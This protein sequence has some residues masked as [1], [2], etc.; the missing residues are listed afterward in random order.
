MLEE[1]CKRIQQLLRYA[2]VITEQKKCWE[3]LA[4]KFDQFQT[5]RNSSQQ[6]ATTC[7]RV[8]KR[9]QHRTSDNV[10]SVCKGLKVTSEFCLRSSL[11]VYIW[12]DNPH[13]LKS[14][15][16]VPIARDGTSNAFLVMRPP[17]CVFPN[18]RCSELD[19]HRQQNNNNGAIAHAPKMNFQTIPIPLDTNTVCKW[20]TLSWLCFY[21]SYNTFDICV[22]MSTLSSWQP[23]QL[24]KQEKLWR[25]VGS[26]GT[27]GC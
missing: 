6:H 7:N 3:S 2:S 19:C 20:S 16:I 10:A 24:W 1:L 12:S 23:M 21:S 4:Q 18:T 25:Q 17:F 13:T 5:L 8:C 26:T 9:T 22:C 27:K 15:T 14:Q 11:F